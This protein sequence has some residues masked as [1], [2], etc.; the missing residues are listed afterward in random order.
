M[1]DG[2]EYKNRK[3][4]VLKLHGSG[5]LQIILHLHKITECMKMTTSKIVFTFDTF[6]STETT[7]TAM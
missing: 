7:C 1:R 5:H 2:N 6:F 3:W 4:L